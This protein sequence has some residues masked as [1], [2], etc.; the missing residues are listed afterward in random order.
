MTFG[1]A[2]SAECPG[3]PSVWRSAK[4]PLCRVSVFAEN[5]TLGK[6][7]FAE[8]PILGT[9]QILRHSA[10]NVFHVVLL[11]GAAIVSADHQN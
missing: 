7:G 11:V 9:R 3:L 8:C 2:S 1:P 4:S 10:K 6:Y 5:Q